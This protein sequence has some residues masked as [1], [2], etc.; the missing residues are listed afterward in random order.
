MKEVA[1]YKH[2]IPIFAMLKHAFNAIKGLVQGVGMIAKAIKKAVD[3]HKAKKAA[4][5]AAKAAAAVKP[6]KKNYAVLIVAGVAVF[7][8][9]VGITWW[10]T[11][12]T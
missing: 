5:A 7:I 9:V 2:F 10:A 4:E 12:K 8:T 1:G 3:K 6:E 11:S